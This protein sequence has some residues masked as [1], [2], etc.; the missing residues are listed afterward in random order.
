MIAFAL[1]L[2]LSVLTGSKVSKIISELHLTEEHIQFWLNRDKYLH[3]LCAS[4][5]VCYLKVA[6]FR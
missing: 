1:S 4:D 6:R 2:S 3:D 5:H